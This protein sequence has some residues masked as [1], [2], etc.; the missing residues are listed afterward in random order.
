MRALSLSALLLAGLAAPG[1]AQTTAPYGALPPPAYQPAYPPAA[2][3]P[4]AYPPTGARPG[5]E[6]GTGASLPMGTRDSNL[7]TQQYRPEI[8]PNLPAPPLGPDS[9]PSDYLRAAQGA[10]AA[11]RTGEAQQAL[12]MAQTRMLDRAVPLGQ[13]GVPSDNPAVRQ[14]SQALNALGAHDRPATMQAI[15]AALANSVAQGN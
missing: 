12:E 2:Y 1:F 15:Q 7:P 6:I 13:T 5:N 4:A 14:I 11:G 9:P 10:L 3:P 8:A